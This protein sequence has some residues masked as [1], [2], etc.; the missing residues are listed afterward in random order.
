VAGLTAELRDKLL[1]VTDPS[2]GSKIFTS[3][4]GSDVFKG[5]R[6]SSAPDLQL[7]Y[8]E[9]YQTSKISAKGGIPREVFEPNM[10]K[11]SG[12]HAS[13]D[14]E[15]TPGILFSSKPLAKDPAIEDLGVT[16]LRYLGLDV[17]EEYEGKDLL[18]HGGS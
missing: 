8:A 17:P 14:P 6:R 3:V 13:S 2:T 15:S 1:A 7:G 4:F 18:A 9:G 16:T 11:W 10:D 12:E 5:A